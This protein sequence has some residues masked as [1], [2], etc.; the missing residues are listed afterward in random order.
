M[1]AR[2]SGDAGLTPNQAIA[3]ECHDHLVDRVRADFEVAL[4]VG[5]GGWAAEHVRIGVDKGQILA[6]LFSEAV[7]AGAANGA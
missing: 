5:F 6:L 1:A 4:H 3:F 7:S 2:P